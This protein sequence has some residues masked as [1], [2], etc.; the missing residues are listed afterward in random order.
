M[1]KAVLLI[2][3]SVLMIRVQLA[4]G[5]D[6]ASGAS[7]TIR[8]FKVASSDFDPFTKSASA[9]EQE[10]MRK[11]YWRMLTYS[12]YFDTRVAWFPNA[13]VYKD[14]YAIYVNSPQAQEHPEWILRD[15]AGSKLYI[16]FGCS[17]GGC[18]QYA[19]DVGN[20]AFRAYWIADARSRL[21][22][23]Y[24]GLFVDDVNMMRS[25]VGDG[26]GRPVVPQDPRTGLQMTEPDWLRYMAEFS[27]QIRNAFPGAEIVHNVI[28]YAGHEDPRIQ[29]ELLSADLI[30]LERG[31]NDTGLRGGAGPFGFETFLSFIDW[32]HE[33]GKGVMLDGKASAGVGQE[34][35]LAAYFLV[36]SGGDSIGNKLG[37]TPSDWWPGYDV[38]LGSPLGSRYGWNGVLRRDFEQGVVLVNEPDSR[39]QSLQVHGAF[40]DA[41]G[42][43]CTAV[44]LGPAEG[45]VLSTRYGGGAVPRRRCDSH[46]TSGSSGSAR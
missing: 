33:H 7:G 13:W 38:T 4:M 20:P 22:K 10:W 44:T 2:L 15:A 17:R 24:R 16:P 23:G 18:P 19:A 5:A 37:G 26:S 14:L 25:R 6:P 1:L 28:W 39:P 34:Y 42:D 43:G 11:H 27:E 36:G 30:N 40:A 29:R 3:A 12:P 35:A 46:P 8:F 21:R 32:L 41:S 31:V 45:V 9:T